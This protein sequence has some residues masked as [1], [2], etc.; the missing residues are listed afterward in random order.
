MLN[1]SIFHIGNFADC[2]L[3]L[4]DIPYNRRVENHC[5]YSGHLFRGDPPKKT[6]NPPVWVNELYNYTTETFFNAIVS[7]Y[8]TNVY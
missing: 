1:T 5:F 2:S 6:Y 7:E 3:S 8:D 4:F